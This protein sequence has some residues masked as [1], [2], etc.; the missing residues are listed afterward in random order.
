[1]QYP[2]SGRSGHILQANASSRPG[3]FSTHCSALGRRHSL[4]QLPLARVSIDASKQCSGMT[5]RSITRLSNRRLHPL[6][7]ASFRLIRIVS[8]IRPPDQRTQTSKSPAEGH[9]EAWRRRRQRRPRRDPR[10][11]SWAP[12]EFT[13]GD[14]K[15]IASVAS[16]AIGYVCSR[17]TL[18]LTPIHVQPSF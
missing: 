4:Y 13:Y 9:K 10:S 14:G 6:V 1:M 11:S 18:G 15:G 16:A 12:G 7:A 5:C 17:D 8:T 2:I 3:P